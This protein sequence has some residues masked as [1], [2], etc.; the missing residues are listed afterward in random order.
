MRPVVVAAILIAA[1]FGTAAHAGEWHADAQSAC[2]VWDPLPVAGQTIGWA[3]ECKDGKASGRGVLTIFRAGQLVERSDGEFVA[4]KQIGFG[5]RDYPNGRY[6][7]HFVDGLFDGN[8]L[9]VASD[10]TR[11][12][13]AWKSGNLHGQG[14]LS[15]TSGLRHEGEFVANTYSGRG[16][17]ILPDGARYD[18]E[19]RLNVPHG[20]GVYKSQDGTLYAGQ[21]EHG[22][23]RRGSQAAYFGVFP[24]ECGLSAD[25]VA[26]PARSDDGNTREN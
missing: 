13:G 19:Y 22:C 8:G 3:G 15:F 7:G 12:D 17:T 10:G 2:R 14:R 1:G 4:G 6:V 16:S 26:L 23:F 18:G 21:W 9:F 20:T 24:E 11:Y 5:S 25:I